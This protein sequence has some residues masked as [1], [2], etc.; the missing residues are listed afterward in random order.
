MSSHNV[1]IISVANKSDE[2]WIDALVDFFATGKIAEDV[3][4]KS[5]KYLLEEKAKQSQNHVEEAAICAQKFE[6]D[7]TVSKVSE[8]PM[9]FC[10]KSEKPLGGY[11]KYKQFETII[12]TNPGQVIFF[13]NLSADLRGFDSDYYRMEMSKLI[14]R[15]CIVESIDASS[16]TDCMETFMYDHNM[17]HF[18]S[19]FSS[20]IGKVDFECLRRMLLKCTSNISKVDL[21]KTVSSNVSELTFENLLECLKL[22]AHNSYTMDIL[23]I[24][25]TKIAPLNPSQLVIIMNLYSDEYMQGE[26]AEKL[27]PFVTRFDADQLVICL[28][29]FKSDIQKKKFL[30]M[31]Y[32]KSKIERCQVAKIVEC[33]SDTSLN[34]ES[35]LNIQ[36]QLTLSKPQRSQTAEN[37]LNTPEHQ[38]KYLKSYKQQTNS[39]KPPG[40]QTNYLKLY[41]QQT[42]SKAGPRLQSQSQ[43]NHRY[44]HC[45]MTPTYEAPYYVQEPQYNVY[46]AIRNFNVIN[47]N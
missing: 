6:E 26:V 1:N 9:F 39:L 23:E 44:Y 47:N 41:E 3:E 20:K 35:F 43:L 37:S 18:L 42:F 40:H 17:I 2:K 19:L 24:V 30:Q 15:I 7:I 31:V 12:M 13:D 14:H 22:F 16:V 33:F 46:C 11:E 28:N 10:L 21:L 4:C 32:S 36:E 45:Q 27:L 5:S 38:T 8:K 34:I 25:S 29:I